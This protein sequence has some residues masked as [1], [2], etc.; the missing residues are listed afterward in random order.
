MALFSSLRSQH[1]RFALLLAVAAAGLVSAVPFGCGAPPAASYFTVDAAP[2]DAAIEK[3]AAWEHGANLVVARGCPACHDSADPATVLAGSDQP[4]AGS[5]AYG[6][7]LTPDPATGIGR[8]T[9]EQ[10]T[11]AIQR[12]VAAD[13]H[14]L[15][16][17]MPR[18][19]DMS[20]A[21]VAAI[22]GYLR[23]LPP[24]V[25]AV[26]ASVCPGSPA[27]R[28]D[29]DDDGDDDGSDASTRGTPPPSPGA[30]LISEVMCDPLGPEPTDEWFELHNPSG[31]AV[32]LRSLT[33]T[34]EDGRSVQ[35]GEAPDLA[36][37]AY[38]LFV[39][40]SEGASA[41]QLPA[42]TLVYG[43]G[44]GA[45]SGVVLTNDSK[46]ALSIL[47]GDVLIDHFP[48]GGSPRRVA[49]S[50][51]ERIEEPAD[52]GAI[53]CTATTSW[54]SDAGLGTPAAPNDCR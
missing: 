12:G 31:A 27:S 15:C 39:R 1:S 7:N 54:G 6:A 32:A 16:A 20:D 48:Y 34:D 3:P 40:T 46:G 13:G 41:Q 38:A 21:D 36:P 45:T 47:V 53:G 49:G 22:V 23:S 18:A 2:L 9:D 17:Q 50:S 11:Q 26:P 52:G 51:I 25:H 37:G 8:W 4:I 30:L 33:I 24:V 44:V 10:L 14:T 43:E 19:A 29:D 35:I 42:P 5:E 28:G